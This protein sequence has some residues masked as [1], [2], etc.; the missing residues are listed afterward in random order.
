MLTSVSRVGPLAQKVNPGLGR[1]CGHRC[2]SHAR[3]ARAPEGRSLYAPVPR[4]EETMFAAPRHPRRPLFAMAALLVL[5]SLSTADDPPEPVFGLAR[6]AVARQRTEQ[7]KVLGFHDAR[8]T[9]T[10]IPEEGALLVGF[11][12]G[13]GKFFDID[14]VY[15]LRPVY[16]TAFGDVLGQEYGL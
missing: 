12:V 2:N 16:R 15:A 1:R 13:V 8:R 6:V 3:L 11:D 5:A 14:S 7:S 4:Q 9:F 10:E